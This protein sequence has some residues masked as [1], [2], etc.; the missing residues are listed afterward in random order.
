[1]SGGGKH[2]VQQ[3]ECIE[4][5]AARHGHDPHK[6]WD[7]NAGL[8]ETRKSRHVLAPGDEV[9]VKPVD[10]KTVQLPTEQIHRLR[11]QRPKARLVVR[12][13]VD[14]E[15]RAGE[16]YT[17]VYR[18]T[19]ITGT[20]DGDGV[21]DEPVPFDLDRAT[22]RFAPWGEPPPLWRPEP[23]AGVNDPNLVHEDGDPEAENAAL[24]A[25]TSEEP[26][27][28]V[29]EFHLRH[30]DPS[31]E[32]SGAQGRLHGLGYSVGPIDGKLGPRTTDALRSFQADEGLE[33]TGELDDATKAKLSEHVEG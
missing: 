15:P 32:V 7:C 6:L 11:V 2:I 14:D 22:V 8:H 25:E 19:E 21:L 27:E 33:P 29:Y 12:F 13:F 18:G 31:A 4:T 1:M 3:G 10:R 23:F 16:A 17:L 30:L 28:D 24:E 20:T 5:I 9:D 26:S